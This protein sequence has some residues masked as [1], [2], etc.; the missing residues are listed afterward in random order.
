MPISGPFKLWP[1][2]IINLVLQMLQQMQTRAPIGKVVTA[3]AE[4]EEEWELIRDEKG[5]LK[6]VI[7]HRKVVQ[8]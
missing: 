5:R 6:N 2:P 7:V 8:S 1:F 3:E 4:N